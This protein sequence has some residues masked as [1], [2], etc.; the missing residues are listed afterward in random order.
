[1]IVSDEGMI[2]VIGDVMV[3]LW[4]RPYSLRSLE[5]IDRTVRSYDPEMSGLL[6]SVSIYR[7]E[8]WRAPDFTN[9]SVRARMVELSRQC[10]FRQAVSVLDGSGLVNGTIRL[11]FSGIMTALDLPYPVKTVES[12]DEALQSLEGVKTDPETLRAAFAALE[13]AR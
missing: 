8:R 6:T 13:R 5:T 2:A 10:R 9:A 3:S 7:F 4:R 11:A 1:M 12:F